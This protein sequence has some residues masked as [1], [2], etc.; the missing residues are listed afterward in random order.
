M[1][2]A[3]TASGALM[4][5]AALL[6]SGHGRPVTPPNAIVTQ[7]REPSPSA[8]GS[9][10]TANTNRVQPPHA[11]TPILVQVVPPSLPVEQIPLATPTV[12]GS[13]PRSTDLSPPENT[14]AVPSDPT[15]SPD[16]PDPTSSDH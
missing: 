12:E 5:L 14:A 4:I 9:G 11:T 15:S 13:T 10:A 7:M 3:L 1:V 6:I 2:V 16:T 8:H